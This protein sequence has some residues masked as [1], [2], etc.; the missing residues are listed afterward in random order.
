MQPFNLERALAGDPVQTKDGKPVTQLVLFNEVDDNY[1]IRAVIDGCIHSI[2]V[3][4]KFWGNNSESG[5]DLFMAP[6][7]REGWVNIYHDTF[8][9]DYSGRVHKSEEKAKK[10]RSCPCKATVKIEWEEE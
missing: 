8:I 4:G 3:C 1:P 2:T 7:K 10:L 5:M 6:V 9:G